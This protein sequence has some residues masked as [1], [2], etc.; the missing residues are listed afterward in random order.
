[1]RTAGIPVEHDDDNSDRSTSRARADGPGPAG[2]CSRVP[3]PYFGQTTRR[4]SRGLAIVTRLRGGKLHV[5]RRCPSST[6]ARRVQVGRVARALSSNREEGLGFCRRTSATDA[7]SGRGGTEHGALLPS[8]PH[9]A[10]PRQ[11]RPRRIPR[12]RLAQLGVRALQSRPDRRSGRAESTGLGWRT[13]GIQPGGMVAAAR[14]STA[15]SRRAPRPTR[16][17]GCPVVQ[18]MLS[19]RQPNVLSSERFADAPRG[20]SCPTAVRCCRSGG[21]RPLLWPPIR[22][23]SRPSPSFTRRRRRLGRQPD[24]SRR[25]SLPVH[26]PGH[27]IPTPHGEGLAWSATTQ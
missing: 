7:S 6:G 9:A 26:G 16:G 23:G 21:T 13:G 17:I 11:P 14:L 5:M 3:D 25:S 8:A 2:S 15:S 19:D 24:W 10:L 20:W 12:R 1:M 4:E 22:S 27:L 18:R